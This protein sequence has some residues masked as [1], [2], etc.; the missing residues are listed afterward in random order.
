MVRSAPSPDGT[1][2]A[3]RAHFEYDCDPGCL[4]R[5]RQEFALRHRR[6]RAQRPDPPTGRRQPLQQSGAIDLDAAD[7]GRWLADHC[8]R[9]VTGPPAGSLQKPL[10]SPAPSTV[11]RPTLGPTFHRHRQ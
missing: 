11:C 3:R 7:L 6:R 8:V 10:V 4:V 1:Q 5:N 2:P 9:R